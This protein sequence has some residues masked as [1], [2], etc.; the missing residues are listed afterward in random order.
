MVNM[1]EFRKL[2]TEKWQSSYEPNNFGSLFYSL[3]RAYKPSLV[4]ELGTKAGYSAFFMAKAMKENGKGKLHCYD[5]W[6]KYQFTS[7]PIAKARDNLKGFENI[8]LNQQSAEGVDKKYESVDMLH[9]DLGNH[10]GLLEQVILPWLPK[11]RMFII[12]EGGS[13][14]RD[15][16]E[17]MKKFS[18][19]PINEWLK[20]NAGKFDY[21]VVEPFPSITL[22]KPKA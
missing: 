18:K 4:V 21:F 15:N 7:C 9:V 6:E 12:I 11:V 3:V 1:D 2:E 14:E 19:K 22:I 20:Q 13:E 16:V 10:A 17:W 5:L 8:T